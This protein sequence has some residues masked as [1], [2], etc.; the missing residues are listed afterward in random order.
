MFLQMIA[1]ESEMQRVKKERSSIEDNLARLVAEHGNTLQMDPTD[2]RGMS[3]ECG[4]CGVDR[5]ELS[6][7]VFIST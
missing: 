2:S 7:R 4:Y 1:V 3:D 6:V 5:D